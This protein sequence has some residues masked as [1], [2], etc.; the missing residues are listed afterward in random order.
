MEDGF[1]EERHLMPTS[2]SIENDE[3]IREQLLETITASSMVE[4]CE[5]TEWDVRSGDSCTSF[6]NVAET[7]TQC[8]SSSPLMT[9]SVVATAFLKAERITISNCSSGLICH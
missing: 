3:E 2:V 7:N 8:C 6:N 4:N 5:V 1:Q 9:L